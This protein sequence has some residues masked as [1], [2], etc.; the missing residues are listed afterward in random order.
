MNSPLLF[1]LVRNAKENVAQFPKMLR[2]EKM[3]EMQRILPNSFTLNVVVVIM[4]VPLLTRKG[5]NRKIAW[6]RVHLSHN[7]FAVFSSSYVIL[8]AQ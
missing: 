7:I 6:T 3:L 5:K 2:G 4:Y 8:L 1:L